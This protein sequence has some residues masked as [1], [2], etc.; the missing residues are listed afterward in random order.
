MGETP[1]LE[2]RLQALQ[3]RMEQV[4]EGLRVPDLTLHDEFHGQDPSGSVSVTLGGAWQ[5]QRLT[6]A[7]GWRRRLSRR[8]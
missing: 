4:L 2:D 8:V 1:R 3:R 5:V 7:D 6:L